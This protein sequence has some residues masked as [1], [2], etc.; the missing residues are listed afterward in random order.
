VHIIVAAADPRLREALLTELRAAGHVVEDVLDST[1]DLRERLDQIGSAALRSTLLVTGPGWDRAE[2]IARVA[3][4]RGVPVAVWPHPR[5][6]GGSEGAG[7]PQEPAPQEPTRRHDGIRSAGAS[8]R[9]TDRER[10][11][12]EWVAAGVSNKGI[13]RRLGLSPNTVKYHITALFAKLGA[14]TRAEAVAAAARRGEL[15]L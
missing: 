11:V 12:L 4:E 6:A 5:G 8:A 7:R 15:S 14:S 1:V 3:L 9:L 2:D 13:A 10:E